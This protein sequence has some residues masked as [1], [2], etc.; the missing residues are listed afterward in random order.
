MTDRKESLFK[1]FIYISSFIATIV[2]IIYRV[3]FTIPSDDILT[4][5]F[6]ILVL[7]VEILDAFFYSIYVFNILIFKKDSPEV[8]SIR[9]RNYPDVDVFIAT[10]NED[11]SLLKDTIIACK[12]MDYPEKNKV[13]IY[14]CDDG[15]RKNIK[16]LAQ[17]LNVNYLT[18]DNNKD[19]KAG[20]YNHAL[21]VTASPY[22]VTFDAD[23]K[24]NKDFL[25]KTIP[26]L[27][28]D[29]DIGFVQLP[30]SFNDND[31][32]QAKFRLKG[33]I[34]YEQDYFYHVIQMA[35]NK[36]NSVIYCGT[37]TVISR[38]ALKSA[39]GF[40]T[41]TITE[42]IAT[43]MLIEAN[44]YKGIAINEDLVYGLNVTNTESLFKQRSRWC[45]GC[46]QTIKNYKII[47]NKGLTLRQKLDYLSCIYYWSFGLRISF[48]ILIPL[49]YSILN[50]KIMQ[51]NIYL[52]LSFFFVQYILKRFIV[53]LVEKNQIS[54]TWNRIYEIVLTPIICFESIKE[55]IGL[56][57]LK[58]E[59]TNKT[60]EKKKINTR[61]IITYMVHLLL[62]S[63]TMF[64]IYVSFYRG[65]I[66]GF[67]NYIVPIFWL[68]INLIYLTIALLFDTSSIKKEEIKDKKTNKYSIFST[69]IL[70]YKY[71]IKG[72]RTFGI[73]T[74]IV[75]IL[76]SNICINSISKLNIPFDN[77]NLVSYNKNLQIKDGNLVN[78]KQEI[79]HL[80]GVS[81]HNL[82][83]FQENYNYSN[84][85]ELR[86]TWG[87][88][89]FRVALY[90]DP[91][92]EGYI[93]NPHI[94]DKLLEL[95]NICI[96]LDLYVIVDWHI[97]KDNNPEKYQKE[98]IEF[99]DEISKLYSFTPNI[100]Y[101]ICNEPN[102]EEVTWDDNI[103]PYAEKVIEVIRKNAPQSLIVV[104]TANWSKDIESVRNNRLPYN[105]I[106]YVV[107][108][109]PE[110]GIDIIRSGIENAKREKLPIIV[111]EC[112]ATDPTGDGKLYEKEFRN[113][114]NYLENY[115]I[116]WIVWQFSD[117][118][119]SS[120]LLIS[121]DKK[122]KK[123][124]ENN[125]INYDDIIK[126]YNINDYISEEG[127]IVKEE[128]LKY[129]N[130]T[131]LKST[132]LN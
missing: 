14:V 11:K 82:Y 23:M 129:S 45:R 60:K 35:K 49:L 91:E 9:K 6:A 102:G 64:G 2:Y 70:L 53:D 63:L 36:T 34:P 77:H 73:S 103:K 29:K 68:S 132:K 3:F 56:G 85:K 90:T 12:N 130:K 86:D 98:A 58:F 89:T 104:G 61:S 15:R 80:R 31:I 93:K 122:W 117:K 33:F 110:G 65:T 96:D 78:I 127:K 123:E 84:L 116:S 42:D 27:I 107:H 87:I 118:D 5:L 125:E 92:D 115:N 17:E 7:I 94:K 72:L 47:G 88:N 128:L 124:L 25:L 59:V 66:S 21:S 112:A 19:S 24:P 44:G 95:I 20:N 51:S 114:I 40:A 83:W 22:I 38:K 99:F 67:E 37:N 97:L 41:K 28:K 50:I 16:D 62:F 119:E 48:Y 55:L 13:H 105:N 79:V 32:F 76:L 113:W 75:I 54:S 126:N 57:N 106:M 100:I 43:G 30:Q 109:Y 71:I 74:I 111:T 8:P 120:S 121:K 46:I 10:I 39:G 69:L 101:E 108:S 18:R 1:R 81:S 26:F 131:K 52:F 4:I